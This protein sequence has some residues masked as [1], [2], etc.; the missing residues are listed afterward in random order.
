MTVSALQTSHI[1]SKWKGCWELACESALCFVLVLLVQSPS[2]RE[3]VNG[4]GV[5]ILI[6]NLDPYI[7]RI[8]GI[9]PIDRKSNFNLNL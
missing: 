2:P 7:L 6:R 4:S 5:T 3:G 8:H 1:L 9:V